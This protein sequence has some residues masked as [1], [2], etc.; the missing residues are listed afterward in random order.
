MI[1]ILHSLER[2]FAKSNHANNS[3]NG[4]SPVNSSTQPAEE[5]ASEGSNYV[6]EPPSLN[7]PEVADIKLQT[8]WVGFFHPRL[9]SGPARCCGPLSQ[10][11]PG[12]SCQPSAVGR[13]QDRDFAA[14]DEESLTWK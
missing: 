7:E 8:P 1:T 5:K 6:E 10:C 14:L 11:F 2:G 9:P 3:P 12:S 13:T 4:N